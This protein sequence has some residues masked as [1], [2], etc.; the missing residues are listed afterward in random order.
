MASNNVN[1][2]SIAKELNLSVATV[3]KALSGYTDINSET[4]EK[5]VNTA[6]KMGYDFAE[7]E[8]R[9]GGEK[10]KSCFI[11]VFVH[12]CPGQ[13]HDT[14]YFAGM[15]EKCAKLNVSLVLQ[16]FS[17]DSCTKVLD[18]EFQPPVMRQGKLAGLIL[19]NRWPADIVKE[20]SEK[21]PCVSI[22]HKTPQVAMD[23][24]GIDDADGMSQLVEYLYSL[25]HRKI[26]FFG[27]CA[28]LTYSH[29]RFAAYVDCLC[30]RMLEYS[31]ELVVDIDVDNLEEKT[32]L[33][34]E[35]IDIAAERIR[36]GVT[37]WLCVD[38][39]TGHAL[40]RGLMDR[41]FDIPQD[42]SI[43]G[44]DNTDSDR[45]KIPMLTSIGSPASMIG[46]E[47]LRRLMS[48][49]RHPGSPILDVKLECKFVSGQTTAPPNKIS[50]T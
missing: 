14:T 23:V 11:G 3:S 40:C 46:A 42:V 4:R 26:G 8:K 20:L 13:W 24:V 7:R 18:V 21:Y 50:I 43:T 41:G 5:I 31:H 34:D 44:F 29:A 49:L 2:K 15:S 33:P 32:A 37:A 28:M 45:Q 22:V 12:S 47:A 1:Q 30:Q 25:G 9:K 19:V 10:T 6:S 27:R 39:H 16:Y 48:R 38:N 17:S 35:K 36:N